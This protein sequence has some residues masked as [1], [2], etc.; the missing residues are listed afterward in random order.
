MTTCLIAP[1]LLAAPPLHLKDAVDTAIAAGADRL[2]LDVMDG[3][4]VPNLALS[5][6]DVSAI[7]EVSSV[8][9]DVHIMAKPAQPFVD[10]FASI[11][12]TS[13]TI[14]VEALEESNTLQ[15]IRGTGHE[16][17]L[18]I[19]P[20]TPLEDLDPWL[21]Q[22]NHV[23]LMGVAPGF[24]GQTFERDQIGRLEKL[25]ASAD[26]HGFMI[27]VDGGVTPDLT[28]TLKSSGAHVLVVGNAFF[29]SPSPKETMEKL[30][31]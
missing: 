12:C 9:T 28:P 11:P 5:T 7:C 30:R 25:R 21:D 10:M 20:N 14:H 24:G 8:P 15:K 17:G 22:L 13:I 29:R 6:A 27:H 2:H 3:H 31:A 18:A 23:V 19:K 1:S 26:I 16:C 4:F